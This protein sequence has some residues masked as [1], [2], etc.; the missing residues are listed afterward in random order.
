LY[1]CPATSI[2]VLRGRLQN[3]TEFCILAPHREMLSSIYCFFWVPSG[4]CTFDG[5]MRIT[6]CLDRSSCSTNI[7]AL[8]NDCF[9][10][11]CIVEMV[12]S[13]WLLRL[14]NVKSR[15]HITACFDHSVPCG[16]CDTLWSNPP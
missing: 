10:M 15:Y 3:A 4:C 6:V 14:W 8:D 13:G 7:R 5:D 12:A 2:V 1:K 16:I 11:L 9:S